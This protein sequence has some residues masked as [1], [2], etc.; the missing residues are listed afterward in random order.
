ML[1]HTVFQRA[2]AVFINL[3]V[4]PVA[5][6]GIFPLCGVAAGENAAI[7]QSRALAKKI[8]LQIAEPQPSEIAPPY[9]AAAV[10]AVGK[11]KISAVDIGTHPQIA[12]VFPER[13]DHV[14]VARH[15]KIQADESRGFLSHIRECVHAVAL[16]L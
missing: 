16:A 1:V 14:A 12:E 8:Q 13:Y 5:D 3:A 7:V 10:R 2:H 4:Q 15:V 6:I 9:V 11:R